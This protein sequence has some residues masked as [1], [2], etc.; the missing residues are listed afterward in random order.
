MKHSNGK[1]NWVILLIGCSQTRIHLLQLNPEINSPGMDG[2][3][4]PNHEKPA[5]GEFIPSPLI[6]SSIYY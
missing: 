4:S 6:S 3:C 5:A 2:E 1:W